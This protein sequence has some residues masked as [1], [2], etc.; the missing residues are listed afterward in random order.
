[1]GPGSCLMG[2]ARDE[3]EERKEKKIKGKEKSKT[4]HNK[5]RKQVIGM[6]F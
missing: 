4:L 1:M 2:R 5:N 3:I 6:I